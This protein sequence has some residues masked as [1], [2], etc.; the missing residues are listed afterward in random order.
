MGV[1]MMEQT[2][3]MSDITAKAWQVLIAADNKRA[4][5]TTIIHV[6][7]YTI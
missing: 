3:E 6:Q 2:S 5:V 4:S 7:Q 1:H